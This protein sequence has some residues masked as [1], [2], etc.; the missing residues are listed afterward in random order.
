MDNSIKDKSTFKGRADELLVADLMREEG[1]VVLEQNYRV[2]H[3]EIDIIAL[4]GDT[5]CFVEVKSRK[6][7]ASLD[8]VSSLLNPRKIRNIILASDSYCQRSHPFAYRR[9][10]FDLALLF[11]PATGSPELTY[12][13]DAFVPTV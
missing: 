1:F 3:L 7:R 10:R 12:I 13:R 4:E 11:S 5:L 9:V 2:G 8:E 6:D